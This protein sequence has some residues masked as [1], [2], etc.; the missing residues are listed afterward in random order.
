MNV[1]KCVDFASSG[2]LSVADHPAK[3]TCR[4]RNPKCAAIKNGAIPTKR[5]YD[6]I[7][8]N[9]GGSRAVAAEAV[10]TK[11]TKQET[12]LSNRRVTSTKGS[13]KA[14]RRT[15]RKSRRKMDSLKKKKR[16]KSTKN[17]KPDALLKNVTKTLPVKVGPARGTKRKADTKLV[18]LT[19]KQRVSVKVVPAKLKTRPQMRKPKVKPE[20]LMRRRKGKSKLQSLTRRRGG[21]DKPKRRHRGKTNE[22]SRRTR[23]RRRADKR[24]ETLTRRQW[25]KATQ[26][27]MV[28]QAQRRLLATT[29]QASFEQKYQQLEKIGEGGF[30]SVYAGYRKN[31]SFAVAIKH[32]PKDEVKIIPLNINGRKQDVPLEALLMLQ[33]S[34]IKNADG[35]SAVVSLLD[36]YDLGQELVLVMEKPVRSVDMFTYITRCRLGHLKEH[37]AKNIMKQLV[38]AAI[39]MHAVNVFHRDLKPGNILLEATYGVPRVRVI[40]FG[41]S[42]FVT[43]EP[44]YDYT[45]TLSYA[46]P[47]F[48]LRGAYRAGP[49]TVWHL[50]AMLFEL[51]AGTKQFDTLLFISQMLGLNRVLSQDCRDFLQ[52]CLNSDPDQRATLV[53]IH[54]HPWLL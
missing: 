6:P 13:M 5:C 37:E 29:S 53:Q 38:D 14:S 48:V 2:I 23:P 26:M 10:P 35:K 42:C 46:P 39:K 27:S 9:T 33:A 51:L 11:R 12:L 47:E 40:D 49:T 50:G 45:G 54:Q 22:W 20:T 4:A 31:D 25:V 32:I 1:N 52:L 41:C 36:K 19:K 34:S 43:E 17:P 15:K 16:V 44:Y 18:T 21:K 30:G 7:V 24:P 28:Q 8:L 3:S